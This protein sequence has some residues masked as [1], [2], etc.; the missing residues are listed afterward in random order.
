M[1]DSMASWFLRR[2]L[3]LAIVLALAFGPVVQ[4]LEAVRMAGA[5]GAA[6]RSAASDDCGG[7][8]TGMSPAA[9]VASCAGLV[10]VVLQPAAI[11]AV[12]TARPVPAIA[13]SAIGHARPPDPYP[14]RL[15]RHS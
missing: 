3:S 12:A 11:A 7:C 4:A 1:L 8:D 14:P 2:W 10:A 5:M 9:C 13:P 6:A 15:S